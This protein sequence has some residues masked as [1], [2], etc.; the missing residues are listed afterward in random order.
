MV[1]PRR[2]NG[3]AKRKTKRQMTEQEMNAF[4]NHHTIKS[5]YKYISENDL[6]I[7]ALRKVYMLITQ[8]ENTTRYE[9]I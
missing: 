5:F 4:R 3:K 1:L 9:D 2:P 7:N 8:N 6:R